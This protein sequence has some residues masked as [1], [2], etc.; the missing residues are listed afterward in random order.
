MANTL[1]T[2]KGIGYTTIGV[3]DPEVLY[4]SKNK[5]KNKNKDL[6]SSSS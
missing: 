6:Y 5:Q 1:N 2:Q 3:L 4:Q